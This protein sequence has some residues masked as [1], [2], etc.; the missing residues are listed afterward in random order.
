MILGELLVYMDDEE[1]VSIE[2]TQYIDSFNCKVWEVPWRMV[3]REVNSFGIA[4]RTNKPCIK[5]VLED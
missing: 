4:E 5:I 3:D 1:N 2:G